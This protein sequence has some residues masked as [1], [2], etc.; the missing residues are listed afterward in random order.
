MWH[1]VAFLFLN[2]EKCLRSETR[3]TAEETLVRPSLKSEQPRFLL[4]VLP[5]W[6]WG[7]LCFRTASLCGAYAWVLLG[8]PAWRCHV[9][10]TVL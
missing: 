3:W 7:A 1:H 2:T 9:L 8:P 10:E 4:G 6:S 5:P